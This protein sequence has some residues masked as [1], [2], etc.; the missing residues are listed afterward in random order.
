M[1]VAL[2]GEMAWT[3]ATVVTG[4][5]VVRL[6]DG[7]L[8]CC[9]VRALDAL[10]GTV[11]FGARGLLRVLITVGFAIDNG[12]LGTPRALFELF[13]MSDLENAGVYFGVCELRAGDVT[14]V[15]G[16]CGAI[17]GSR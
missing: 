5:R 15:G 10:A 3:F 4:C 2:M 7:D 16:A 9:S 13:T 1:D 11:V 6:L 17:L 8:L 12:A 14:T